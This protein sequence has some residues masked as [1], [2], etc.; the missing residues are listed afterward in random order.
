[1]DFTQMLAGGPTPAQQPAAP[2]GALPLP[3]MN[4]VVNNPLQTMMIGPPSTPQEVQERK[5]KWAQVLEQIKNDPNAMAAMVH[6]GTRLMQPTPE[7]QT[8]A[9]QFGNAL[10]GA[11]TFYANA[12][13]KDRQRGIEDKK[14]QLETQK[15][16]AAVREQTARAAQTEAENA[17]YIKTSHERAKKRELELTRLEGDIAANT[18]AKSLNAIQR[19]IALMKEEITLLEKEEFM[20][21]V[22]K[23][24]RAEI[25]RLEVKV[26]E[27]EVR[28]KNAAT[29]QAN[30]GNQREPS[31]AELYANDPSLW[32]GTNGMPKVTDRN[33]RL[34]LGQEMAQQKAA[35]LKPQGSTPQKIQEHASKK[36]TLI[37]AG[38]PAD[39]ADAGAW[40]WLDEGEM[41]TSW[42]D[43]PTA[44]GT[45]K[46]YGVPPEGS[47]RR[48]P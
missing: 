16:E 41:P 6:M 28:Y 11:A 34:R 15:N 2:Q 12:N 17:E 43:G 24:Q 29:N 38:W 33:T 47:V 37:A 25:A 7:W 45:V 13:E 31:Q 42:Q 9:G 26:K 10:S 36:A 22:A 30:R 27:A 18:D 48:L 40:K 35:E 44:G 23:Q 8:P 4:E 14:L 1:M 21:P 46:K 39:K 32:N 5:G 20:S 3:G 19:K